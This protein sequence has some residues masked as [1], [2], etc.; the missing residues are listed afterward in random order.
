MTEKR[1]AREPRNGAEARSQQAPVEAMIVEETRVVEGKPMMEEKVI[2]GRDVPFPLM[3][4][5]LSS[6]TICQFFCSIVYKLPHR[7]AVITIQE[8]EEELWILY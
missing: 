5:G 7:W 6:L 8:L 2:L 4:S 1:C 3:A